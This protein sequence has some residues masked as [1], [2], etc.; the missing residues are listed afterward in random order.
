MHTPLRR[1]LVVQALMFWQGGFLFYAAVVVPVGTDVLGGAAAQGVIT[2]RVTGWLNLIGLACLGL[3]AWDT[4]TTRDPA[5]R[6]V[7]ARWWLW[8]GSAALLYLL[9]FLH[10]VL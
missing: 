6:R 1:F 7:A 5:G 8:I 9:W 3:L 4:A 10:L 2:A